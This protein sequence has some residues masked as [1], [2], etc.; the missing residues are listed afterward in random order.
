MGGRDLV[1]VRYNNDH[2]T[3][4]WWVYNSPRIDGR[5]VVRAHDLGR[6]HNRKL[7]DYYAGRRAIWRVIGDQRPVRLEDYE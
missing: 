3:H 1:F 7:I 5:T 2:D 4:R 6:A